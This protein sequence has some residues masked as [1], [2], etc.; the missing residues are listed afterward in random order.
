M[1]SHWFYWLIG[2]VWVGPLSGQ[3]PEE[4][5]KRERAKVLEGVQSVP[6]IGAPG[7]VA[8]WGQLAFPILGSADRQGNEQA[9]AAV[10]GYGKGR[11]VLFGQNGYLSGAGGGDHAKLLENVV[12]WSA[13]GKMKPRVGMWKVDEKAVLEKAG[14][15]VEVVKELGKA[16]LGKVDVVVMNA[17][18]VTDEADGLAV[19]EWVKAGGGLVAG[20]TGW[21]F[22]QTSGGK[23]LALAH[24]LNKAL[25]PAGIG[26]TELSGFDGLQAFVA[27]VDLPRLMNASEAIGVMKKSGGGKGAL[28]EAEV[29]QASKAIQIAL[30]AQPPEKSPFREAVSLALGSAGGSAAVPTKE[31]P[32]TEEK[33]NAER[34]RLSM[35]T[36]MLRLDRAETVAAHPAHEVFPEKVAANAPRGKGVVAVDATVPGWA[37][38]GFYAAAGETIEVTVPEGMAGKGFA[39]RIGCHSDVLYD[40]PSWSRAPDITKSVPIAAA[41]TK[42]ASAFGGLVYIEVPARDQVV[43]GMLQ[44]GIS[45]AVA[46]PL[47]V[48]GKDTDE[49]WNSEIK[50]R[51]GPW[52]EL[53]CDKMIV[54]VPTSVAREVKNPTM[55]MTFWK[56]AVEAQDEIT[57][58]AA[59]RRRPERMVADVQI[60]AGFMHSGYPIMLHVPEAL[61]MVTVSRLKMPGWGYHHEVGHNHQRGEFTFDGT[62]EVT[63]NVI[64]MWVYESVMK[65]DPLLGHPAISVE[66]RKEHVEKIASAKGAAE[67]WA[68]WKGNPFVAL[69]TYI[70]LIQG[71]GWESWRAYLHS[72]ADPAFGAKPKTDDETRDQFLIRYSKI[73]K[74]N[75]GPFF[76]FWGIPVSAGAKE[77]VSGMEAWMPGG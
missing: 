43:D 26:F 52:A 3:I 47:F 2:M 63:N 23:E 8:I 9:V 18:G 42:V 29:K 37:S 7:P 56:M 16:G 67:K 13:G 51:P 41:V 28:N 20:M 65:R 39:V 15:E 25:Q 14:F 77:A 73:T 49:Q 40:L 11:V 50:M 19:V 4:V 32:F 10:A 5:V 59:E 62:G 60:S 36:R 75:L 31:K 45:G 30:A 71:F 44:V 22:D 24:G 17:Q 68:V 66:A 33:E 57:N 58:Q 70:Q 21:A 6:K 46:A 76:E 1:K 72:F 55:V 48:L 54:T 38:T 74:K 61:E 35:E 64:G 69:T 53:A 27:R 34:M 12:R